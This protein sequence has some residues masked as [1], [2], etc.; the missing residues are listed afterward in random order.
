MND[1][2]EKNDTLNVGAKLG[3]INMSTISYCNDV[4]ILSPTESHMKKLL[5]SCAEFASTW[6]V[7]F[8]A[9]KSVALSLEASSSTPSFVIN[10]VPIP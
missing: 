3:K 4:L 10:K 7:E 5:G 9:S 8:K 2:L 1:L 6:K